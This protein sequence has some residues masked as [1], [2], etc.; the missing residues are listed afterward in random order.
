MYAMSLMELVSQ[1]EM[2]ALNADAPLNISCMSV[3]ELVSQPEMSS[4]KVAFPE[5][6]EFMSVM[7][8]VFHNGMST[9]PATPQFAPCFE[10]HSLPDL[11]PTDRQLST[12]ALKSAFDPN[13]ACAG[14][15]GGDGGSGGDGGATGD[16][17]ELHS[18]G[19]S[20]C[21]SQ[22]HFGHAGSHSIGV[23]TCSGLMV[24]WRQP[25]V[26][27]THPEPPPRQLSTKL[28]IPTSYS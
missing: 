18:D 20:S 9:S 25:E 14:G 28:K 17:S 24:Q 15:A 6:R 1:P 8:A 23:P 22:M 7:P 19:S 2:S 27:P 21:S 5:N 11:S 3:T 16:G 26:S 12:A 10:Q 13:A 4:L